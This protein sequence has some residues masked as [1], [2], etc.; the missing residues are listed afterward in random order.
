MRL[1]RTMLFVPG[2]KPGWFA[3]IPG[4]GSDT[5]I[6]DL[7]DSVPAQLKAEAR[8]QVS[9]AISALA[10]QGQRIYVRINRGP[11]GF[12]IDDLEAVVQPELEGIVL[13]K[14]DGPEDVHGIHM[15]VSEMEH[16]KGMNV[17]ATQFV[18][19]LETAKSLYFAYEIG[20]Q[21]R[22]AA[23]AAPSPANGDVARAVGYQ[24]THEGLERLYI[25]SRVVLAARAANVVPVGGLWQNVH[26]LDGLRKAAQFNRQLGFG[27]ELLL[28]PSNVPV[29]NEVYS[30]SEEQISYYR[31]MIEVY[32]KAVQD[33]SGAV[34]YEGE[35][36]D[37]AHI[38]T[39]KEMLKWSG[40]AL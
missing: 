31:K 4:Y 25:R 34:M 10:A 15:I 2:C 12:D 27:G 14:I 16:K 1:F 33:G 3:K 35:H 24:Y 40:V 38:K 20:I 8:E 5:I 6:L 19:T 26:D 29:L 32:E 7:E 37:L 11:Y 23:L 21:E 30:L 36:I 39:A 9:N 13:P 28:H 17:G 18:P 22:V